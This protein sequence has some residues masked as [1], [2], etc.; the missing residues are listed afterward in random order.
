MVL[1]E[2]HYP[3]PKYTYKNCDLHIMTSDDGIN[4]GNRRR[5][6]DAKEPRELLYVS[7]VGAEGNDSL[8]TGQEFYIYY[9]R[10]QSLTWDDKDVVRRKITLN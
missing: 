7:I 1:S 2:N 10:T 5:I 6:S 9:T 4:W 3:P 8:T